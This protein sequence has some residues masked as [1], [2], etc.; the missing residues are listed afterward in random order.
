MILA[1]LLGPPAAFLVMASVLAVQAL[2]FADGG[3]LA[4]GCNIL[5]LGFFPAFAA[6]PFLYRPI[7]GDPPTPG[8]IA[9]ASVVSAVAALQ[10]GAFA[11]VVE[12]VASG[13]SDL[14]FRAFVALMQPIHLAIGIVEGLVTAAVVSFVWKS[15]PAILAASGA[16]KPFGDLS[17]RSVLAVLGVAALLSGGV[18]SWFASTRPD[19]LEWAMKKASGKEEL[20][21]KGTVHKALGSLQE[22]LAFLPGYGFARPEPAPVAPPGKEAPPAWPAPDAG[23]SVAGIVGG[24][25]TLAVAALA[26]ALLRKRGGAAGAGGRPGRPSGG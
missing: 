8:R 24:V 6:Y 23:T 11:V 7:A 26:G 20:E 5:N 2:F 13:V 4:L 17:A 14:P 10:L 3:I 19:G 22:K 16:G 9:A 12:T 15:R 18:L 1:V 25:I 21:S